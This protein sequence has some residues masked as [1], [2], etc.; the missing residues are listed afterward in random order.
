MKTSKKLS[1]LLIALLL[2]LACFAGCAAGGAADV[3]LPQKGVYPMVITDAMGRK[4]TIE[5]EPKT[6]VSVSPSNTEIIFA[7]GEGENLVG[8]TTMCNYPEAA[9]KI[10]K[11]GDYSGPATEKIIAANPD[12]ILAENVPAETLAMFEG[13][14]IT[15]FSTKYETIDDVYNNILIFGRIL[16]SDDAAE[17]AVADIKAKIE[18]AKTAIK[19]LQGKKVFIDLGGFYSI[20]DETFMG[21][22]L[23]ELGAKNIVGDSENPWPAVSKEDIILADP[24]VYISTYTTL[25]ELKAID[26]FEAITAFKNGNV[27]VLSGA[28]SDIVQRPGPRLGDAVLLFAEVIYPEAFGADV[29]NAA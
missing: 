5:S 22:I 17:A 18:T 26:G 1:V 24:D 14:G 6:I 16:N 25:D 20:S 10:E 13:A 27:V 28:S 7:L 4:V 29:D 15:V 12:I 23:T 3:D 11:M 2:A 8:V 9:L 19:G 21:E